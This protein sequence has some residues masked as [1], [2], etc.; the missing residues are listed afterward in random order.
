MAKRPVKNRKPNP[1]PNEKANTTPYW[2][3][4][5]GLGDGV[6]EERKKEVLGRLRQKWPQRQQLSKS[7]DDH[8]SQVGLWLKDLVASFGHSD[9]YVKE[10]GPGDSFEKQLRLYT[11]WALRL[12]S[13]S[14]DEML[15]WNQTNSNGV[16]LDTMPEA[17]GNHP[18]SSFN[19][20]E[21]DTT[22]E[23]DGLLVKEE[24]LAPGSSRN[25]PLHLFQTPP[26]SL[27]PMTAA[28]VDLPSR[29][30]FDWD[31]IEVS[32]NADVLDL[33]TIWLPMVDIK[34]E[35]NPQ[36]AWHQF[37]LE[38]LKRQFRAETG[39]VLDTDQYELIYLTDQKQFPFNRTGGYRIALKRFAEAGGALDN[40]LSLQIQAREG[41]P[42]DACRTNASRPKRA[43][44]HFVGANSDYSDEDS[45]QETLPHKRR[46][47]NLSQPSQH[48]PAGRPLP[49]KL[50]NCTRPSTPSSTLQMAEDSDKPVERTPVE[51]MRL[52]VKVAKNE[53]KNHKT[54]CA[55]KKRMSVN[56]DWHKS[57]IPNCENQLAKL[58]ARLRELER[59]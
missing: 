29:S 10:P 28:H 3:K 1:R 41:G 49:S 6:Y 59:I 15:G 14:K 22:E 36:C 46:S 55:D 19:H 40:V 52:R 11:E 45:D 56:T 17:D 27:S 30:K 48:I 20:H 35:Q 51:Q 37:E 54:K 5:L 33:G 16:S 24:E 23:G 2:K 34:P 50:D 18:T 43:R 8:R 42:E 53:L 39:L 31:A 4:R 57:R 25:T 21:E 38:D 32:I 13:W 58:E 9:H 12:N 26:P 44:S 7:D 47:T